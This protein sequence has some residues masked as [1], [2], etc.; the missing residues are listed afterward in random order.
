MNT[1]FNFEAEPFELDPEFEAE[2]AD[3]EWQNEI[4]RATSLSPG[5]GKTGYRQPGRPQDRKSVV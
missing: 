4:L 5:G 1:T 2:L 3:L